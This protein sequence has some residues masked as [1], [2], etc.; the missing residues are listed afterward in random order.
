MA[1]SSASISIPWVKGSSKRVGGWCS[2][3]AWGL[4]LSLSMVGDINETDSTPTR[5]LQ[6]ESTSARTSKDTT[7]SLPGKLAERTSRCAQ[8]KERGT[9]NCLKKTTHGARSCSSRRENTSSRWLVLTQTAVIYCPQKNTTGA[10]RR[11]TGLRRTTR[12]QTGLSEKKL[13]AICSFFSLRP[14]ERRCSLRWGLRPGLLVG[15]KCSVISGA[16][17]LVS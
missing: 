9:Q 11:R 6:E 7:S 14:L 17:R 4:I 12:E 10:Q 2:C 16:S 5:S 3:I 1:A 15:W 13:E 8:E